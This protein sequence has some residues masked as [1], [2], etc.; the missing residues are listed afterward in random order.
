MKKWGKKLTYEIVLELTFLFF[1]V[2]CLF[3]LYANVYIYFTNLLILVKF[4][5]KKPHYFMVEITH[6]IFRRFYQQF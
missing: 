1:C 5:N 2:K 3:I 4:P 6:Y